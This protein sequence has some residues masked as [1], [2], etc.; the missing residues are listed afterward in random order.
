VIQTRGPLLIVGNGRSAACADLQAVR[1]PV[2]T[3]NAAWGLRWM[4]DLH[5]ALDKAQMASSPAVY[6]DL[7]DA[8][9]LV[10][11]GAGWPIGRNVGFLQDGSKWSRDPWND[12]VVEGWH[13][14]GSVVYA[15]LQ[16]AIADGWGPLYLVGVDLMGSRFDGTKAASVSVLNKQD[17]L[18]RYAA[19]V[20][21]VNIFNCNPVSACTAFPK[22]SWER[23]LESMNW[24]H[25]PRGP[26]VL[27]QPAMA[28]PQ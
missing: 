4:P 10:V 26:V 6:G 18:F 14:T 15:A 21:V 12:G 3:T 17:H 24:M 28:E 1:C 22:V 7:H 8:G 16:L 19:Q 25:A 23:A 27:E 5:I 11:A 20:N 9:R 13:G 2:W